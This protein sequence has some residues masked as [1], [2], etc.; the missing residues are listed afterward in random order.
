MNLKSRRRTAG[1]SLIEVMIVVAIVGIISGLS[2]AG[3]QQIAKRGAAQN[4]AFEFVA[5]LHEARSR[6][7]ERGHDVWFILYHKHPVAAGSPGSYCKVEDVTGNFASVYA[8]PLTA[9]L[10]KNLPERLEWVDFSEYPGKAP[11]LVNPTLAVGKNPYTSTPSN[12]GDTTCTF[13]SNAPDPKG[14]IVF[15]PTGSASFRNSAGAVVSNGF[16]TIGLGNRFN[17]RQQY[18]V[19]IATTGFIGVYPSGQ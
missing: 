2:W 12:Q 8:Q 6:A 3:Y 13:C 15:S 16:N 1:F 7:I 4:G 14:A 19:V 9:N 11:Y 18:K 5:A 10:C 17:A